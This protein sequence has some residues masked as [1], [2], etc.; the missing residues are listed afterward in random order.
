MNTCPD[1]CTHSNQ[2]VEPEVGLLKYLYCAM[3]EHAS[4][5]V[6]MQRGVKMKWG[7]RWT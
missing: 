3:Q 4:F 6:I 2:G 1:A 7:D 5:H